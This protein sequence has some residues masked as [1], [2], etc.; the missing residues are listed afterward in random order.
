LLSVKSQIGSF[1][2]DS[3][4]QQSPKRK[5]SSIFQRAWFELVDVAPV[6]SLKLRYWDMAASTRKSADYTVGALLSMT[7]E[8]FV[9]VLDIKRFQAAPSDCERLVRQTADMDGAEVMIRMEQ[10][11]GASGVNL[12][13]HYR[14]RVLA[15]FAF[16]GVRSQTLGNKETRAYP[17]ASYSQAN[18]VKLLKGNW[19]EAF[20]DEI[21]MFPQGEHDDQ[22][23]ATAGAFTELT[24]A[25][26]VTILGSELLFPTEEKSLWF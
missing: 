14:R 20:L 2:F 3:L 16:E 25:E 1:F 8:G 19:N 7:P 4:Y 10:E 12:I 17:L 22:V 5:E 24:A 15:G 26:P 6:S 18:N 21:E 13:D 11:S 23:D 9:Y